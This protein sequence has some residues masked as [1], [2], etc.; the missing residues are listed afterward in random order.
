MK[1]F[2]L[3]FIIIALLSLSLSLFACVSEPPATPSSDLPSVIDGYEGTYDRTGTTA[4]GA[5]PDLD[6]I[7]D[8]K[9]YDELWENKQWY[10]QHQSLNPS[11][12][13]E[14][15]TVFS[16]KG[17]FLAAKSDD[18]CVYWLDRNRFNVNTHFVFYFKPTDG[19]GKAFEFK[20]DANNQMPTREPVNVRSSFGGELNTPGKS[21]GL[22]VEA[23]IS[24]ETLGYAS[25]PEKIKLVPI[26]KYKMSRNESA[27]ALLPTFVAAEKSDVELYFGKDGFTG[28]DSASATLGNHEKGLSKTPGWRAEITDSY[29]IYSVQC[30]GEDAYT[31]MN[32]TQAIFFKNAPVATRFMLTAKIKVVNGSGGSRV[33]LLSYKD[34]INYR[35]YGVDIGGSNKGGELE[36][37]R[38]KAWTSYPQDVVTGTDFGFYPV[39]ESDPN[40]VTLTLFCNNGKFYYLLNGRFV[41]S[42][43]APYAG[44]NCFLGLYAFNAT[45]DFTLAEARVFSSDAELN[46][47][48]KDY[49]YT[50]DLYNATPDL[51]TVSLSQIAA[52]NDGSG[53]VTVSANYK[54]AFIEGGKAYGYRVKS[55]Y[56]TTASGEKVDLSGEAKSGSKGGKYEIV[57]IPDSVTVCFE[58]EKYEME[59]FITVNL[60][61]IDAQTGKPVPQL[62]ANLVGS[63]AESNYDLKLSASD[64]EIDVILES[65]RSWSIT[66]VTDGYRDY[67]APLFGGK[68]VTDSIGEKITITPSIIGGTAYLINENGSVENFG[69]SNP[70]IYWDL[71]DESNDRVVF[72]STNHGQSN[73]YFSGP[74]VSDYQ[75]A[76]VEITN[77]TDYTAFKS[78]EDDPAAGFAVTSNFN[79]YVLLHQNGV[80]TKKNV[81]LG[82]AGTENFGNKISPAYPGYRVK[83]DRN[84][85]GAVI[86]EPFASTGTVNR[87]PYGDL[88]STTSM[89]MIRKGGT[90]Y[91]Y[92][93]DGSA[94]V[95]PDKTNFNNMKEI[96]SFY[97]PY[98]TGNAAIGFAVTVSYNLRLEFAN[99]WI[100]SG[101]EAAEFADSLIATPFSVSGSDLVTVS[102]DGII[103]FDEDTGEGKAARGSNITLSAADNSLQ[104]GEMIKVTS[105]GLVKYI[106]GNEIAVFSVGSGRTAFSA[107]KVE[108][109]KVTGRVILPENADLRSLSGE[110]VQGGS[111]IA[112]LD[113]TAQDGS[114]EYSAVVEKGKPFTVL[115]SLN[116]FVARDIV[117]GELDEAIP[118][119]TFTENTLL[120]L[121]SAALRYGYND[122]LGLY[123]RMF[124]LSA[125]NGIM[126]LPQSYDKM[127]EFTV[128]FSV[129]RSGSPDGKNDETDIGY[130]LTVYDAETTANINNQFVA[131]KK[132]YRAYYGSGSPRPREN[133]NNIGSAD[134]QAL[135][136]DFSKHINIR[137]SKKGSTLK[138]YTK[139]STDSEFTLIKEWAMR[140]GDGEAVCSG[141]V[142]FGICW[143]S[144]GNRYLDFTLFDIAVTDIAV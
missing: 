140:D 138:L 80:R 132:G 9:I 54:P 50:V 74:T 57:G 20:V 38:L 45:A 24:W 44:G 114:T 116:G 120:A 32:V 71:S 39:S 111:K 14:V 104:G 143:T 142:R 113:F 121:G 90:T 73:V 65:G 48:I 128:S 89:L 115:C 131:M 63:G 46:E 79:S 101:D 19:K 144:A 93:A 126:Y 77:T 88:Q 27:R 52:P 139:Y 127:E 92:T 75:V 47:V 84:N 8:G 68:T 100:L 86:G 25:A 28:E 123:A 51:S 17:L 4:Y 95:K 6:V 135:D 97:N 85:E 61:F 11:F 133:G 31:P 70:N 15:T 94:R 72:T 60:G 7:I 82:A 64:G 66:T 2:S 109:R 42:E 16:E 122:E 137:I 35:A 87:V 106:A 43:T 118:D 3:L 134:V 130:G 21:T 112:E 99:Y 12:T 69:T 40:E 56:Y 103:D 129:I 91:I 22:S 37:I 96:F 98:N 76:Y 81:A 49:A 55:L 41:Q 136:V 108:A 110:I 119:V 105:G 30:H 1:K 5:T 141:A 23:F 58:A 33:G 125:G 117:V 124:S 29:E 78:V 18:R 13:F 102:G 59:N 10:T 67:F 26:Y 36:Q 53:S 107:E 62:A 34:S 83:I